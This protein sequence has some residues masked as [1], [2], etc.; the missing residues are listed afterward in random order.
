MFIVTGVRAPPLRAFFEVSNT[1]IEC[2][3]LDILACTGNID[4][5]FFKFTNRETHCCK[6]TNF[7]NEVGDIITEWVYDT[8]SVYVALCVWLYLIRNG[9]AD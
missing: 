7:G 9:K 5:T 6:F 1:P 4:A 8:D 2:R 3:M